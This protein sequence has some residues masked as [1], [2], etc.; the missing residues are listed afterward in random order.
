MTHHDLTKSDW[1]QIEAA[2]RGCCYG[3]SDLWPELMTAIEKIRGKPM[4]HPK[5]G[6][7]LRGFCVGIIEMSGRGPES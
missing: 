2:A 7:W 6:E 4:L 1:I 5:S 3:T